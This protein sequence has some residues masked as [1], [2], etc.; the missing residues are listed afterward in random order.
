MPTSQVN[1]FLNFMASK[2]GTFQNF[3]PVPPN[4]ANMRTSK[5]GPFFDEKIMVFAT[6]S[7]LTVYERQPPLTLPKGENWV[8]RKALTALQRGPYGN[9]TAAPLHCNKAV[10]ATPRG[11]YCIPSAP[12]GG[13][14]GGFFARKQRSETRR[15][16]RYGRARRALRGQRG[17]GNV[18][19]MT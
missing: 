13:V 4:F 8:S 5:S 3:S 17:A 14:R 12:F 19:F 11:P 16:F 2:Q 6:C 7:Y 9:A 15:F 18:F 1:I 10:V